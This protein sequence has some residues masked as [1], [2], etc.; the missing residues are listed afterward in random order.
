[1]FE[2]LFVR[3]TITSARR[4]CSFSGDHSAKLHQPEQHRS[5]RSDLRRAH[6][7][8]I[9]KRFQQSGSFG[10]AVSEPGQDS[11]FKSRIGFLLSESF[12]QNFVHCFGFLMSFSA[13]DAL[14]E[15]TMQLALLLI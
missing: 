11:L 13:R 7:H 2:Q 1:M 3:V 14:D 12:F 10:D 9:S 8:Q 4:N 6:A 15:M 5:D